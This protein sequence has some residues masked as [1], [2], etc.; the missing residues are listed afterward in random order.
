MKVKTY[1]QCGLKCVVAFITFRGNKI[2]HLECLAAAADSLCESDK[3]EKIIR[4]NNN[5]SLLPIEVCFSLTSKLHSMSH[6]K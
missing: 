5:W 6:L 4:S 3:V 1:T 2:K